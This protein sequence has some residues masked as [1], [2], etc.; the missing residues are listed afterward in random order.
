VNGSIVV[1]TDGG[2]AHSGISLQMLGVG[3][4]TFPRRILLLALDGDVWA[5]YLKVYNSNFL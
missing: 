5:N 2:F 1:K 3:M 4:T